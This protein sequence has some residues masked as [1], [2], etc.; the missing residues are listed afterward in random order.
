[1]E[2]VCARKCEDFLV[3]GEGHPWESTQQA[4]NP[5][6][7]GEI[8]AREFSDDER[9]TEHACV[10]Q[11][12]G[13]AVVAASQMVHPDRRVNQRHA[14]Q[15]VTAGVRRREDGVVERA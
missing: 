7:F 8:A 12:T 6:A 4:Q 5:I 11:Q 3:L 14:Q 9:M 1:M 13:K 15:P 2:L 10:V